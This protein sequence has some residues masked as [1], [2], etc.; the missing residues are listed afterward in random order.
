[1]KKLLLIIFIALLQSCSLL[2]YF[3]VS[4]KKNEEMS[5]INTFLINKGF[6]TINSFKINPFYIDSLSI[7]K[8]A[9]NTYKLKSGATASPV[10]LRIYNNNG[11]FLYGW[12]Q[13]FGDLNKLGILDSLPFKNVKYLPVNMQLSFENDISIIENISD[14][15]KVLV[16]QNKICDYTIIVYWTIWAGWYSESTLK[17]IY[18]YINHYDE[19]TFLIVKINTSY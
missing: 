9:L 8:F 16:N 15:K 13:C 7:K 10:Q 12:E 5:E 18:K 1:M 11:E 17:E 4:E 6:D 19:T 2:H 3:T 14:F